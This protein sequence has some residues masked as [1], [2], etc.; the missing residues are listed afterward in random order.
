MPVA[1]NF[2]E[3]R[4]EFQHRGPYPALTLIT[5]LPTSHSVGIEGQKFIHVLD[6]VRSLE[7][8]SELRE[9]PQP[10]ERKRFLEP[11]FET[12]DGG[13]VDKGQFALDRLQPLLRFLVCRLL[14]GGLK[15]PAERGFLLLTQVLEDVLTLV[16]LAS[17]E[18]RLVTHD[19]V[20]PLVES[21]STVDN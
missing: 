12:L 6:A 8:S 21:F 4:L 19:L 9:Q 11:F 14:I 18:D 5:V 20:N 15:A 17:L 2:V 1:L 13:L 7:T 16:P 3:P 10:V